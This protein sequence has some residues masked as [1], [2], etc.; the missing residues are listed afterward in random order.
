MSEHDVTT[1]DQLRDLYRAP[2]K[3]VQEKKGTVIE[4]AAAEFVA[5]S[6]FCCLATAG[7][8]G[9][10]DVSPRGGPAGQLK[11][12]RDG[13]TVALPDLNGN[14]LIDS[15]TNIVAN[16]WAGLLVMIPGS[17]ETMRI[18][19]PARLTADPEV[20]GLWSEELRP[21]KLAILIDVDAAFLHCAKA[22]RRGGVWKPETWPEVDGRDA[23]KMFN[24]IVGTDHDPSAMRDALEEG[25]KVGLAE[26]LAEDLAA[27]D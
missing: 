2:S 21:P 4:G 6:P 23:P 16:P 15:L 22:F 19:G 3:L 7:P 8:D 1:L 20:L 13:R 5:R 10:C 25:Y 17:D 14:N 27:A 26:D 11:L 24:A 9:S 12:L 18:D